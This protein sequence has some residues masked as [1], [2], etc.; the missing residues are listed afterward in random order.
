MPSPRAPAN[1]RRTVNVVRIRAATAPDGV[2]SQANAPDPAASR[3]STTEIFLIR[4][5]VLDQHAAVDGQ[6]HAGDH[7]CRIAGEEQNGVSDILGFAH[8]P[9]R[10][11]ARSYR[12]AFFGRHRA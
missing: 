10:N 7:A 5:V 9:Q 12:F 2:F 1:A 11:L 4:N 3:L 6:R 8:T